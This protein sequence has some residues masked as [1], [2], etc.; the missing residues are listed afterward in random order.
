[1]AKIKVMKLCFQVFCYGIVF[2]RNHVFFFALKG[3]QRG[4]RQVRPSIQGSETRQDQQ[5]EAQGKIVHD[6]TSQDQPQTQ[7]FLQRQTSNIICVL[8]VK[9]N[10]R[11]ILN[12][13]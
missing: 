5:G 4:P 3:R 13:L 7:A 2:K 1:M 11:R 8:F 12:V 9:Q 6:V 10:N